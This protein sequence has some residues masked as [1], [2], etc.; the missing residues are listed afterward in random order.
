MQLTVRDVATGEVYVEKDTE[1]FA[2]GFIGVW[3]PRERTVE[4]TAAMAGRT[5]T[6][7]TGT[8]A[9]DPTCM[10]ELQLT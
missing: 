6:V 9:E 2:N 1:T 3:L 7:V 5:G 8:G 10:T 4:V